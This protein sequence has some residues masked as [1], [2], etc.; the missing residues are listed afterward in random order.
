MRVTYGMQ[1][2]A[3]SIKNEYRDGSKKY[4]TAIIAMTV[5]TTL[6]IDLAT[7]MTTETHAKIMSNATR[8]SGVISSIR[9]SNDMLFIPFSANCNIERSKHIA[10]DFLAFG[11]PNHRA[12][13]GV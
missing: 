8:R 5:K 11:T 12:I 13:I 4:I 6:K 2:L 9:A 10:C 1:D 3:R 7:V